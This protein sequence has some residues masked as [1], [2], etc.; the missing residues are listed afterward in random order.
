VSPELAVSR[1]LPATH[2]ALV[3]GACVHEVRSLWRVTVAC[4]QPYMFPVTT[5]NRPAKG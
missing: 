5:R 4:I 3:Q 1:R 2:L